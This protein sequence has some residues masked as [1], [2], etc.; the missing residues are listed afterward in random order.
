MVVAQ[1]VFKAVKACYPATGI[2]VLAPRY[3]HALLSRMPEVD[4]AIELPFGHGQLALQE[5]RRFGCELRSRRFE[6]SIV[7]PNSWKSALVPFWA[8]IPLRTG[9]L[10]ELRWGLLNDIRYRKDCLSPRLV[11][12]FVY[13][14][15]R[16]GAP[17]FPVPYPVL[18]KDPAAAAATVERLQL[19]G[20]GPVLALCPGAEYGSA[21]RWPGEYFAEVARGKLEQGWRVWVLGATGDAEVAAT[22]CRLAGPTCRNLAGRTRLVEAI[23]LLSLAEVTV[24]NDSGLM[25]IAS[26]LGCTVISIFGST[27]PENTP[28]LGNESGVLAAD[29]PCRPCFARVCRYGHN[30]CLHDVT[31]ASVLNLLRR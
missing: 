17:A 10:G 9:Y 8:H 12:R 21:K 29:L 22:V 6:W 19:Q 7:L 11:D 4:A 20:E 15:Q 18:T 14:T 24:T 23:D 27:D 25:H 28:P 5:R 13:L 2:S 26:S 16:P 31:P 3:T 30:Q 1:S